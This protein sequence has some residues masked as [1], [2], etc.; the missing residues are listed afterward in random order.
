MGFQLIL[1]GLCVFRLSLIEFELF[2]EGCGERLVILS[3]FNV[4]FNCFGRLSLML[5]YHET[6]LL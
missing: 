1:T 4:L 3:G 5:F 6:G 2:F